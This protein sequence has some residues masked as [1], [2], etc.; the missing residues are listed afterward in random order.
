M[1]NYL[2]SFYLFSVVFST[3]VFL[4]YFYSMLAKVELKY[5]CANTDNHH[6]KAYTT[7]VLTIMAGVL[8]PILNTYVVLHRLE[9]AYKKWQEGE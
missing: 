7:V 6:N 5:I 1:L 2:L 8:I 9:K 4:E 3:I